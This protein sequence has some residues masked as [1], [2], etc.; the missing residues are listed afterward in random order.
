VSTVRTYGTAAGEFVAFTG[1][2]G[3]LA[4]CGAA[5]IE[6]FVAT[7]AG[8]QVKT[9]EQK[10]GALRSFLRFASADGLVDA[11]CLVAVPAVPC[12]PPHQE[13]LCAVLERQHRCHQGRQASAAHNP[14]LFIRGVISPLLLNVVLHGLEGAAGVRYEGAPG[15]QGR[16]RGDSPVLVAYADLCRC[17]H[18]SAYAD[19]GIMPA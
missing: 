19:S 10:L 8:Y 1:T 7:L 16:T 13:G 3:G 11:A 15:R 4:R 14:A 17:R 12:E 18:K 6:A 2:R 9:V 5:T